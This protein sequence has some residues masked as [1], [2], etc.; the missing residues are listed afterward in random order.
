[1]QQTYDQE[2]PKNYSAQTMYGVVIK[3]IHLPPTHPSTPCY[4]PGR[5][6][7]SLPLLLPLIPSTKENTVAK[8]PKARHLKSF[9]GTI[10][11]S[12]G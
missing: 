10:I 3:T 8:I 2:L 9:S 12:G 4:Y 6:D 11:A 7:L 5:K 1:M